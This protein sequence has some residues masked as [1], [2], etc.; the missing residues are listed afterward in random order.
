MISVCR[1]KPA[2]EK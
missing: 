1:T 2:P